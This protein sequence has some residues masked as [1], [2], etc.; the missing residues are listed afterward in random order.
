MFVTLIIVVIV[1][2]LIYWYLKLNYFTLYGSLPG[3]EPEFFFGNMRQT[4]MIKRNESVASVQLDMKRRFGNIYQFWMGFS[5]IIV[6]SGADDIQHIFNHRHIYDL[7]DLSIEKFSLLFQ[8]SLICST[9]ID[10]NR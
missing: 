2:V 10:E 4:G 9:G 8:D 7:G 5:R 6:V 3:L 1:L